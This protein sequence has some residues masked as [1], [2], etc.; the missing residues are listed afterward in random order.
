MATKTSLRAGFLNYENRPSST[1]LCQGSRLRR[2]W[3][4]PAIEFLT[5]DQNEAW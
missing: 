5:L 2:E 1:R 3:L 4:H